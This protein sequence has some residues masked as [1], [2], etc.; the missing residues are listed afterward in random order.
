MDQAI[1]LAKNTVLHEK[2][3]SISVFMWLFTEMH[4]MRD[5]QAGKSRQRH[6]KSTSP[7]KPDKHTK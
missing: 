3:Q 6:D 4:T 5:Q 2:V 7:D 1:E